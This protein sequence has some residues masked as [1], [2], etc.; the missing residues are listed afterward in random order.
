[1]KIFVVV[2]HETI[3]ETWKRVIKEVIGVYSTRVKADA[4]LAE[5]SGYDDMEIYEMKLND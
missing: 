1:M 2:S 4:R 3:G 5:S